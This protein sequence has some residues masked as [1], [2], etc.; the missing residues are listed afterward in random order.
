M[1]GSLTDSRR[2][3]VSGVSDRSRLARAERPAV[4]VHTTETQRAQHLFLINW[5][6]HGR[7]PT[8][9]P[10]L[11]DVNNTK[12]GLHSVNPAGPAQAKRWRPRHTQSHP[13]HGG[14]D[15]G[16]GRA[17]SSG[18]APWFLNKT[19]Q[20]NEKIAFDEAGILVFKNNKDFINCSL[21]PIVSD[22]EH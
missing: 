17:H 7:P 11:Q 22:S 9:S 5:G 21:S 3:H 1:P 8:P 14:S 18:A 6:R 15:L 16:A 10:R 19:F 13:G 20:V 12:P 4:S 2:W